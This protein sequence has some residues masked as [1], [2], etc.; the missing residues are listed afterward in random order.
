MTENYLPVIL[1]AG[2]I[3][4]ATRFGGLSKG[5]WQPPIVVRDLLSYVPVAAFTALIVPDLAKGGSETAPRLL[6]AAVAAGVVLY[7]GKLWA[8]IAVGMAVFWLA[9]QLS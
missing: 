9:R 3:T 4:Y 2:A 1:A 6:A 8:C 5:K 7:F